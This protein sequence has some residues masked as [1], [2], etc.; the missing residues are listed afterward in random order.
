MAGVGTAALLGR[1]C[2][3]SLPDWLVLSS[4]L[5]SAAVALGLLARRIG[6]DVT[7]VLVIVGFLGR[8]VAD[9]A[10]AEIPLQG[11][12]F[13]EVVVFLFLPVLVFEAA[14][15]LSVRAFFRNL[16]AILTL[17]VVGLGL[18]AV[19][20]GVALSTVLGIP[21]TAA[22]LFGALI[23]ATDPVAVVAVFRKLGVPERLLVL[24]EGESLLNDA[25]A[26]VLTTILLG[27]ALGQ[28]VGVAAGVLDFFEVFAGG[29]AI[30]AV[31]GLAA[32]VLLPW[33]DR[34]LATAIT[35]ALAYGGFVLAEHVLGFSGVTAAVAGGLTVAGFAPSR[36]STEVR[37]MLETVWEGLGAIANS[38][39]FL[40]IG[41]AI[42]AR[43]VVE[44]IDAIALVIV[45]VLLA[46]AVAVIPTM[47][48]L[49]RLTGI[50]PVG[51]RNEAVLIWGGLRGGVALALALALPESLGERDMFVAMTG[52][53]VLAT[54]LL[55]ATT[56]GPLMR[57]LGLDQ[58]SR[59]D[60]FLAAV[61][62]LR[63]AEAARDALGELH[64]RDEVVVG[65][66]NEVQRHARD[67]LARIELSDEE[68]AEAVARQGLF[69][70]RQTYQ[71]LSDL[72]ALR[73]AAARTLLH[74][75]DDE[76][77]EV[78]VR[79]V[80]V[81]QLAVPDPPRPE[82][83]VQRLLAHLP[84]P[85]GEDA[86]DIAYSE[87]MGRRL[88]ARRSREALQHFER[89][90]GLSTAVVGRSVEAFARRE[91]EAD[92]ALAR[93]RAGDDGGDG[94]GLQHRMADA[95]AAIAVR[96]ALHELSEVGLLPDALADSAVRDIERA[97]RSSR[98]S[99]A[100]LEEAD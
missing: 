74:E 60:R 63:S 28:D 48:A 98:S 41:L 65:R 55:N 84:E 57:R 13:E 72:G 77:E 27:A 15:G 93:F 22:L 36:A 16:G 78:V 29:A 24:V 38:L 54:L 62:R 51:R 47:S 92:D 6:I 26:I 69:V 31:L 5:L 96:D 40:L 32:A 33:L 86:A 9:A 2:P 64:V 90:T 97:V 12:A 44:H 79:H 39:L 45:V 68:E 37:A 52:G 35:V 76:I 94:G 73:P 4:A 20:V 83:L 75:V 58:P 95:L 66:L 17:A 21:L 49:E 10:G 19:L 46:R 43:L 80:P 8:V 82:L 88:A 14:L 1:L 50:T 18:S 99:A 11:E 23:A 53:V 89:L 71:R 30:G 7:V 56:I 61:A 42:E 87:A 70:E 81:E 85:A 34:A 100:R 59:I 67:E 25:V 3:V 91:S